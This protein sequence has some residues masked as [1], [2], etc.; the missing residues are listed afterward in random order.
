[1]QR[2]LRFNRS[3][4]RQIGPEL[5]IIGFDRRLVFSQCKLEPHIAV[6]MAVRH[7]IDHLS[8]RPAIRPIGRVELAPRQPANGRSQSERRLAQTLDQFT[9]LRLGKT[10]LR[11][12][13]SNWVTYV[14]H[15]SAPL[16][17]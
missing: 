8:R 5:F 1:M 10:A 15:S 9:D 7:V 11:L 12:E 3:R 4:V 6:E 17:G 13:F 14:T 16:F 2:N